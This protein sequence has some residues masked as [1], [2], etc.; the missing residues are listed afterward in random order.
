MNKKSSLLLVLL[1]LIPACGPKKKETVKHPVRSND[2]MTQVDIPVAGE[3]IK[4]FF[5]E[6]LSE[7][8][9]ADDAA[10]SADLGS[11]RTINEYA[12]VEQ[13]DGASGNLKIVYFGFNEYS[14]KKTQE[15]NVHYDVDA[16][17][18]V[19]NEQLAQGNA[20]PEVKIVVEG[21]ACHSAGSSLYNLT[22]SERRAKVVADRLVTSGVPRQYVKIVGR[23]NEV[24]AVLNGKVVTGNREEQW[25]NRR[26]ELRVLA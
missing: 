21:H 22:L 9:L 24:P 23:G 25:P 3:Q 1:V 8:A 16:L 13:E 19:I 6:D 17:L 7:Y 5:D 4:S 12:W 15:E 26:V 11:P 2:T 10:D 18:K 20:H 14:I